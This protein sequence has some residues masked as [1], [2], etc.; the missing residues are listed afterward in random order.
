MNNIRHRLEA[1][2]AEMLKHNL[3]AWYITGTDPHGSEYLPER[4]QTRA[5]ISGFTGSAGI[6]VITHEDAGLW[7]DS[8]YFIQA[9]KQLKGTGIKLHKLRV[10]GAVSPEAWIS[11]NLK[12]GGRTGF[13][14]Q[15]MSVEAF[16][17]LEKSLKKSGIILVET[18]DLFE[19]I[20]ENRPE[21]PKNPV[22]EL[23][24]SITGLTRKA[25]KELIANELKIYNADF[26][27]ITAL[28]EVA[29]LFNL[30][31]SDMPYNPVFTGW[32]VTGKN[33][34][35]LFVNPVKLPKSLKTKLEGENIRL[36]NYNDF[37]GWLKTLK[38]KKILLDTATSNYAI[39]NLLQTENEIVENISIIALLKAEKN[40][41]ELN[42]FREA[43]KKDGAALI[44]FLFWLKEN[45]GKEGVTEYDVRK[46]LIEFRS[47]QKDFVGESFPS[48]VGYREHGAIVHLNVGKEEALTLKPEGILLFDSGGQYLHGTTDITRTV[49]LGKVTAQQKTDFTLVLKGMIALSAAK[50]PAGTKGCQLDILARRA[51]WESGLDYG[52]GTGHGIGHFLNVH[53]GPVSIRKEYNETAI[54]P[55]MVISNEP[56]LYRESEYGIRTENLILCVEKETTDFGK[57]LEFETLTLCPIDTKLIDFTLLN[58]NET[59]WLNNYHK[60][61]R[62]LLK[63]VIRKELHTFLDELAAEI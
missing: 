32:A 60:E 47:Q 37:G 12:Q 11:E 10:P 26:Q 2:R 5:F 48:I 43:M 56:G 54:S 36:K 20:W 29:W 1:L 4:W 23:D 14:P 61:V 22:F 13:D 21:I 28:D 6:V 51:L 38:N 52:H 53:E 17:N 46:K 40:K 16:R 59:K 18:S 8:R 27:I 9:E 44:E 41:T 57:F 19:K 35:I 25:K 3:D 49:A 63:P 34:Q 39:S 50:F 45:I 58:K 15:T 31:G 24:Q 62:K 30:R 33:E 7:T 42:G 55:G